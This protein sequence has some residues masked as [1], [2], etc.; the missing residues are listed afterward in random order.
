MI[1][2]WLIVI[3]L[4]GGLLS[5]AAG[6]HSNARPRWISLTTMIVELIIA[7]CLWGEYVGGAGPRGPGMWFVE[8]H[9]PWIP[10]LGISFHLAMDG[11]SLLLIVLTALLGIMAVLSS[12]TEIGEKVGFFHFNLLFTL[13][14][15]TGVFLSLDLFLFYFFWELM[16]LP[17]YFLIA[18]WGHERRMYAA[19]K[20]FI[21]T[22]L[23]GLFML[24]AILGLVVIH[25]RTTG[26]LSFDYMDLLGTS[27]NPGSAMLLLAGFLTAFLVKLPA[28]PV[29]TW[30]PD[31]HTEAP[32]AGSVV[33]AGL[34]L[35]TGAYGLIR[36][37]VP[38]F[39]DASLQLV[40][41]GMTLG[42]IGIIYG[43]VLAFAQ[44]DLKRLIAYTSISHMGFVLL[45]VSAGGEIALQGVMIQII[46][47]GVSTG[48]LFMLA[49][50]LQERMHTRDLVRMGG[51]WSRVPR[52]GGVGLFF[53]LASLGLPGLGNF[54][55]EFLILL[56]VSEVSMAAAALAAIGFI[57][58]TV[59]S[60]WMVWRT[61]FGEQRET[62]S[63]PDYSLREMIP[64][65]VL[66][67]VI[68]WIGLFP[69]AVIDTARSGLIRLERAP[70]AVMKG[71][72]HNSMLDPGCQVPLFHKEGTG[73]INIQNVRLKFPPIPLCQRL[74]YKSFSVIPAEAGIQCSSGFLGPRFRGDDKK[75]TL[76]QQPCQR[77]EPDKE[78][79]PFYHN[80]VTERKTRHDR[81]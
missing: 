37:A 28:V 30:L 19:L 60:L 68:V 15:I 25:S 41:W 80:G 8:V 42:V 58:A 40:P 36:F 26:N 76:L 39:P 79:L 13:S 64:M 66:I 52:M 6:R 74:S 72:F 48:A 53:A 29:H 81:P 47:H 46:C 57:M 50:A 67:A 61:F 43:A 20:F 59:Y 75:N 9:F 11:I 18:L 14:G 45:G 33:L 24:M 1:L 44:T 17:M 38:L 5:W 71:G 31:A 32:T 12:W 34:L 69:Q 49:G 70:Q 78:N 55:A 51:L 27:M 77:G 63:I 73:E 54:I 2:I 7:F 65:A 23:G 35:K 10:Q 62:W 56:G 22:Q 16:L 3:P 21:F 4:S